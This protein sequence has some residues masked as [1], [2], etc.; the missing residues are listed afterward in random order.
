MT[1]QIASPE[2][3]YFFLPDGSHV[4]EV[5]VHMDGIWQFAKP[6]FPV[7]HAAPYVFPEFGANLPTFTL[8]GAA[9]A[10]NESP[11]IKIKDARPRLG[12]QLCEYSRELLLQL[13]PAFDTL[14]T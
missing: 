1:Y 9:Q 14:R 2:P 6:K 7:G 10:P 8:P 5:A 12:K 11:C 13:K 3:Q 4:V